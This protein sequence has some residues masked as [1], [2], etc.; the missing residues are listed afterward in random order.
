MKRNIL[1]MLAV[2]VLWG[3]LD[4]VLHGVLMTK[5]YMASA[6]LWRPMDEIN[7][8]LIYLVTLISAGCFVGIYSLLAGPRSLQGALRYG[9]LFG[10]GAG[11]SAG[12]GSYAIMPIPPAMAVIWCLGLVVESLAGAWLA[13]AIL[14]NA[15]AR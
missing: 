8:G 10:I 1:T 15:P 6:P 9:L 13:W 14:K 11:V 7:L 12:L 2:F 3:V 4:F 5:M